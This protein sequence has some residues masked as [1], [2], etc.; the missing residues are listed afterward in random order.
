MLIT[1][2]LTFFVIRYAWSYPL[3][4]CAWLATGCFFVDRPDVLGVQP[5]QADRTAAGS[6][7]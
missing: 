4:G 7:C 2:V 3:A 6:R 5:A 1:T